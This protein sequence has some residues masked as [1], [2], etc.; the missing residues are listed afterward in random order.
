[1][2][3]GDKETFP[4]AARMLRQG[5]H[6]V[7]ARSPTGSAGRKIDPQR[8]GHR[9]GL[10]SLCMVQ[11]D[12]DRPAEVLFFH[13]NLDK[14]SLD[15]QSRW[16]AYE[17]RW[18]WMTRPGYSLRAHAH[19]EPDLVRVEAVGG[20]DVE[21]WCWEELMRLRCAGWVDEYALALEQRSLKAGK[22]FAKTH[23]HMALSTID[24]PFPSGMVLDE[25]ITGVFDPDRKSV[26]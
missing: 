7:G 15:V 23:Q 8:P 16:E 20:V 21:R 22:G 25:H 4:A 12:P 6:Y 10:S 2:G 18:Q 19:E 5:F 11:F 13:N 3:V 24:R 1:M 14:F 26:V 9:H 17:R